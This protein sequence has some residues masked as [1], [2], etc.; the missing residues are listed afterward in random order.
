MS[1]RERHKRQIVK[2]LIEGARISRRYAIDHFD[3]YHPG[4]RICELRQEGWN[5][6][7]DWQTGPS[8]NRY[9]EYVLISRPG[10]KA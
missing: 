6:H 3:C 2:A 8:G 7:T 1:N 9:G 4:A 10:E 5:I